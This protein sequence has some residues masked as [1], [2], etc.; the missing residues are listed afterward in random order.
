MASQKSRLMS[1]RIPNSCI[2]IVPTERYWH[3]LYTVVYGIRERR[4]FIALIGEVGTGKINL[5][6]AVLDRRE[7]NIKIG[8]VF[9]TDLTFKQILLVALMDLNLATSARC[10][11]KA[12]AILRL[13][14]F[15]KVK[16]A[17]DI[18]NLDFVPLRFKVPRIRLSQIQSREW[19]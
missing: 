8:N 15:A 19:L 12:D 18:F 9:N 13:N 6:N 17:G 14:N 5:L 3:L 10:L 1:R 11:S 7:D 4:G 2:K 16:K